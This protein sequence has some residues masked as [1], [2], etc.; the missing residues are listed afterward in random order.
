MSSNKD[1]LKIFQDWKWQWNV[2]WNRNRTKKKAYHIN[3]RTWRSGRASREYDWT[4]IN[5]DQRNLIR[6][7][8]NQII[9]KW[10]IANCE[11]INCKIRM[12]CV[13]C[14]CLCI[15]PYLRL[16]CYI[17]SSPVYLC[18]VY[19][20]NS[21]PIILSTAVQ[22]VHFID[23]SP[24]HSYLPYLLILMLHCYSVLLSH[25]R[26]PNKILL[27]Y[28]NSWADIKIYAWKPNFANIATLLMCNSQ[29]KIQFLLKLTKSMLC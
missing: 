25:N 2:P 22:L 28:I 13:T 4:S 6:R 27:K 18:Y 11:N 17:I 12:L 10:W 15:S 29:T 9:S 24:S 26:L 19:K 1:G 3:N 23:H 20:L 14:F 21:I 16:C 8:S 7:K 5:I